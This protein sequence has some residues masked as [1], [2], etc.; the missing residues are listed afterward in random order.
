MSVPE[1]VPTMP[2]PDQ[3]PA[4]VDPTTPSTA[5]LY[6][7]YLGGTNNFEVDRES[8]ER[9]RAS[10]PELAD[11]AW[12]N[13]GFHGRAAVWMAEQQGIRQFIDIGP[14]LPTQNNT[15]QAVHRV[16]P[17]ARIAYVDVDPMVAAYSRLLLEGD[18]TTTL[19]TADLRDIDTVLNHP[20][21]RR[22]IDFSQP[23]GV[24]M[25]AVMHFIEDDADPWGMVAQYMSALPAGSY[26]ALSHATFD[27]L[28]PRA[29]QTIDEIYQHAS[30]RI[31]L[32]SRKD[33]ERFFE[34]LEMVA[35]YGGASPGLTFVG[36][37]GAEDP[38][39]AD[40]DGSRVLCC[41]VARR[42]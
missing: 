12:A 38:E 9:L 13:R 24:L 32:R 29:V 2:D 25:T 3:V 30:S 28:P 33:I 7:Y 16:N 23:V 39:Q 42:P 40:S 36:S 31:W 34:G 22:M 37:W 10:L 6:D 19:I 27:K 41:A 5:R 20:E 35:P 4:G 26:L 1:Q 18:G 8:G 11:A 14:G 21:L 15:H 17:E